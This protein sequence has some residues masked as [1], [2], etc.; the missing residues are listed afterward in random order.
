MSNVG[1]SGIND[2]TFPITIVEADHFSSYYFAQQFFFMGGPG[3][4]YIGAQPRPDK[5]GK[6]VLHA[7]FSSFING[8]NTTNM[9]CHPGADENTYGVSCAVDWNGTYR[10]MYDF[11]VAYNS[12]TKLWVGT[13]VDTVTHERIHIGSYKLPAGLEGLGYTEDGFVEWYP[14]NNK[15]P[16]QHCERLPY[17]KTIFGTPRTIH[18]GLIGTLELATESKESHCPSKVKFHTKRVAGGVEVSCGFH[19]QTGLVENKEPGI[20]R[21]QIPLVG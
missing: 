4:G 18:V 17:Q 5:E 20:D 9:N 19:G 12:T 7:A 21:L 2:I 3:V 15:Q 13:V 8:T 6:S 11:E 14:W 10:H 16:S 1:L